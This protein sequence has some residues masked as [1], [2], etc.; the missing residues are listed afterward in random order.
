MIAALLAAVC[1]LVVLAELAFRRWAPWVGDQ[2][3]GAL[4]AMVWVYHV[5]AIFRRQRPVVSGLVRAFTFAGATGV[6]I[7]GALYLARP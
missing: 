4:V 5:V 2:G 6:L 7:A 3:M 1:G